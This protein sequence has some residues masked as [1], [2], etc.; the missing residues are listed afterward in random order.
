MELL[1]KSEDLE[2]YYDESMDVISGKWDNCD[3]PE[4]LIRGIKEYK[5]LFEKIIPEKIIWDLTSMNYCIPQDL[6]NWILEFLDIPA[7]RHGIDYKVAHILSPDLYAGLSVMNMYTEGKTTFTP[8]FFSHE[9]IAMD[10]VTKKK[11]SP[12]NHEPKPPRLTIEQLTEESIGRLILDV[13]LEELSGYLHEVV[14]V[15]NNRNF[16]SEGIHRFIELTPKEKVVLASV[17]HGKSSKEISD[18]FSISCETVKTH[19]RNL[20]RKLKC[21]NMNELMRYQIFL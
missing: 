3:S 6:Q 11:T 18:I 21:K 5:D 20:L 17:I 1:F 12:I 9:N 10:W 2:V 13:D 16:F 4:K 19:R 7:C 15:L 8:H 14:K